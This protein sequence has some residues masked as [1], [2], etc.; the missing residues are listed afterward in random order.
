MQVVDSERQRLCDEYEQQKQ[1]KLTELK[2]AE[3][4][5]QMLEN[6]D[7]EVC[8]WC[9]EICCRWTVQYVARDKLL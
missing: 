5:R 8:H 1:A 9:V 6:K 3:E 2:V 4:R 7:I